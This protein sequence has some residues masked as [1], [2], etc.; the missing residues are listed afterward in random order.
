MHIVTGYYYS[1][2]LISSI[3]INILFGLEES[4]ENV[5]RFRKTMVQALE[6]VTK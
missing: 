5:A 4:Y 1:Y 3:S 6:L 2:I